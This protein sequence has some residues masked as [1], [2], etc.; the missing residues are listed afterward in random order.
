[1]SGSN[2]PLHGSP[3]VYQPT[4]NNV[5]F[6]EHFGIL[7]IGALILAVL[8]FISLGLIFLGEIWWG[9]SK[10]IRALAARFLVYWILLILLGAGIGWIFLLNINRIL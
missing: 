3:A 9:K 8:F 2:F 6:D 4:Y 5:S 7:L 10:P 1:M